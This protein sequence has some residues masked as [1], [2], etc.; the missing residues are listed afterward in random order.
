MQQGFPFLSFQYWILIQSCR[1]ASKWFYGLFWDFQHSFTFNSHHTSLHLRNLFLKAD[2]IHKANLKNP[3]TCLFGTFISLSTSIHYL[4]LD[5]RSLKEGDLEVLSSLT[6][7]R[8]LELIHCNM[9]DNSSMRFVSNLR[10]LT[11][12]HKKN[13]PYLLHTSSNSVTVILW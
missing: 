12:V 2:R 8:G 5:C 4:K 7:L 10:R 9:Q 1:G 3:H 13:L 11:S 6:L